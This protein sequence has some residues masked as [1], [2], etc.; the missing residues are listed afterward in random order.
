MG[1]ALLCACWH[2]LT[3]SEEGNNALNFLFPLSD[4]CLISWLEE[5]MGSTV[6]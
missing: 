6:R 4:W 3:P 5:I 1:T 2:S